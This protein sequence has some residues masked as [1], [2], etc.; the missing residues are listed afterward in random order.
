MPVVILP[1]EVLH[2]FFKEIRETLGPQADEV[3]Y[4]CG[5]E[6]GQA[7]LRTMGTWTR[8]REPL[9]L[10]DQLG[11]V[12][13]RFGWFAAESI[14]VDP[15]SHQARV[16][17]KRSLETYGVEGRWVVPACHFLR[18]FFAGFFRSL[19]WSDSVEC[20][21]AACRGKGDRVCEFAITNPQD[22]EPVPEEPGGSPRP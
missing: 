22:V 10:V 18:G 15:T 20:A 2:A 9:E 6:A 12:C 5:V 17:L 11:D 4:A 13:A 1:R 7:F 19:F 16:R 8:G 3:L 21:E 14:E